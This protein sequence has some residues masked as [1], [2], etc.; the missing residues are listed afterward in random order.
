MKKRNFLLAI[1]V[2]LALFYPLNVSGKRSSYFF[3]SNLF[4]SKS[5]AA[6]K[7]YVERRIEELSGIESFSEHYQSVHGLLRLA[8]ELSK[9]TDN[10]D[11]IL[12]TILNIIGWDNFQKLGWSSH[13]VGDRQELQDLVNGFFNKEGKLRKEDE[14]YHFSFGGG[15]SFSILGEEG[16]DQ[17]TEEVCSGD[18]DKAFWAA[19][20][21]L[22]STQ[23][24]DIGWMRV[25]WL[26]AKKL[27]KEV[28][29][30]LERLK[31]ESSKKKEAFEKLGGLRKEKGELI[32]T[33]IDDDVLKHFFKKEGFTFL[34]NDFLRNKT[35]RFPFSSLSLEQKKNH[36]YKLDKQV[37]VREIDVLMPADPPNEVAIVVE[38][39]YDLYLEHVEKFLHTLE[40]IRLLFSEYKD[41]QFRGAL[42]FYHNPDSEAVDKANETGLYLIKINH[43]EIIQMNIPEFKAASF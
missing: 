21:L 29:R 32:T 36:N 12:K 42:A 23:L 41:K 28:E 26:K 8:Q 31:E 9:V 17:F 37:V 2:F 30:L 6:I 5:I 20:T 18:E 13:F 3:C 39:K 7:K 16:F 43:A 1:F 4:V 22:T 24:E 14:D 19:A 11:R 10:I 38:M 15:K 34:E 27:F 35:R 33:L 40:V 25:H